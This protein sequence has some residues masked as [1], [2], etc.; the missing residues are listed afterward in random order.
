MFSKWFQAQTALAPSPPD[1]SARSRRA[2][3]ASWSRA[4]SPG[5]AS[6]TR[7]VTLSG[8]ASDSCSGSR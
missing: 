2:S 8:M 6:R 4:T 3:A 1:T 7:S 5:A